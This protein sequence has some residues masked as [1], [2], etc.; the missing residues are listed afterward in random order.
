MLLNPGSYC[1]EYI[2]RGLVRS[3]LIIT[4]GSLVNQWREELQDQFDLA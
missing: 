1:K 3:A 2:M 4:P